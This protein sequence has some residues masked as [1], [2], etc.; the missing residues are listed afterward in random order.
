MYE[1]REQGVSRVMGKEEVIF[2]L[3]EKGWDRVKDKK[4]KRNN[5]NTNQCT[6]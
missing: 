1:G 2:L 3:V 6:Y 4:D 5:S